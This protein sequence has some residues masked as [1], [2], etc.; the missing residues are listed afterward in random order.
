[1]PVPQAILF[2]DVNLHGGH[3]HVHESVSVL[4]DFNDV[5]SSIVITEGTWTFFRDANFSPGPGITLGPG[6]YNSVEAV[7]IDNDAISSVRLKSA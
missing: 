4:S 5:T 3:K 2:V 1:M 6:I 7:G